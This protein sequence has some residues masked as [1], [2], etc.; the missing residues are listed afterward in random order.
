MHAVELS[1]LIRQVILGEILSES[2]IELFVALPPV[3]EGRS[4]VLTSHFR[5]L[6]TTG[7]SGCHRHYHAHRRMCQRRSAS[8]RKGTVRFNPN[9][10]C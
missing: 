6:Y 2:P 8:C 4:E 5:F 9:C 7:S 3:N 1:N 10:Q